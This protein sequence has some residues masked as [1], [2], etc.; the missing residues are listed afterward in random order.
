[1]IR[2]KPFK[3]F[4]PNKDF[5]NEILCLPY[6]V[7]DTKEAKEIAKKKGNKNFV[8]IIRSE[9]DLEE[10][11]NPYDQSVY[12]KAKENLTN[13]INK[14]FL[15]RDTEDSFYIYE[16]LWQGRRQIGLVGLC[17]IQDYLEKKIKIHEFTLP[18]K[19]EDRLNHIDITGFNSEPV[20]FMFFSQDAQ[21]LQNF[22]E[23]YVE[24]TT[25]E[26]EVLDEQE[27]QHKI[28]YVKD[29]KDI[30]WIIQKFHELDALYIADGHHRTSATVRA[31]LKRKDLD[32]NYHLEK[33]YHWFLSVVFPSNHLKTLGYHRIVFDLNSLTKEEFLE[34]V[35][36]KFYI[37]K[38]K[39]NLQL[40]SFRMFLIDEWFTLTLKEKFYR[41][42]VIEDL[43]VSYLQDYILDPILGIQNPRTSHRISFIGGIKGEEELERII[44]NAG[45]GVAF[46]L[47]PT[48]VE[49]VIKVANANQVMPPKSTWFEP[50]LKSGFFL[51]KIDD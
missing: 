16:L 35:K 42:E 41:Q 49:S 23:T 28:Y 45:K 39:G 4:L 11:T 10:N 34:H 50:K 21:S 51:N 22:L 33:S 27:T 26:Y 20:F 5:V 17:H 6:D 46:S 19:E 14:R 43:D 29:K 38:G 12:L 15:I 48:P 3:A 7:I 37:Q 9:I 47:Y 40:H 44:R 30:E 18:D 36:Q 31:A 8:H 24:K 2:F 1:M 32:Q 13:F 25:P